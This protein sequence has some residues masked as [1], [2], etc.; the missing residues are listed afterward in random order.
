MA[1]LRAKG[2]GGIDTTA[3]LILLRAFGFYAGWGDKPIN[4]SKLPDVMGTNLKDQSSVRWLILF[5]VLKKRN[6]LA[7]F[8]DVNEQ[9]FKKGQKIFKGFPLELR[10]D[11]LKTLKKACEEA[12][13]E[14]NFKTL[15]EDWEK[16]NPFTSINVKLD[17]KLDD[18]TKTILSPIIGGE[19]DGLENEEVDI[20]VVPFSE[21]TGNFDKDDCGK[22]EKT[23]KNA[24][25]VQEQYIKIL[26][27]A[28]PYKTITLYM[29]G[30][31]N[32]KVKLAW[33]KVIALYKSY[34]VVKLPAIDDANAGGSFDMDDKDENDKGD[35]SSDSSN[36][37]KFSNDEDRPDTSAMQKKVDD[38][39]EDALKKRLKEKNLEQVAIIGDGNCQ[40]R[41]IA[42]QLRF[43]SDAS[44]DEH[45]NVRRTIVNHM[46]AY[47]D[48]Y[49]N[50]VSRMNQTAQNSLDVTQFGDNLTLQAAANTYNRNIEIFYTNGDFQSIQPSN[51]NND[52]DIGVIGVIR[53]IFDFKWKHYSSTTENGEG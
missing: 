33:K 13:Q 8:F 10:I 44:S 1:E 2:G 19:K 26:F 21:E 32:A 53:L 27:L 4:T 48:T 29:F 20:Y 39:S 31:E 51:R 12:W 35:T 50:Y 40:F 41:A 28:L 17:D 25:I 3:F 11:N 46:Q 24:V 36:K 38:S 18:E 42:H 9:Y 45:V 34:D 14:G 7:L 52:D 23:Y 37:R 16:A 49:D 30:V 5:S 15:G 22:H 6:Q 43:P 47:P